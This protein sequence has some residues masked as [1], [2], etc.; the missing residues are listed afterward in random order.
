MNEKRENLFIVYLISFIIFG[1]SCRS[2]NVETGLDRVEDYKD[3]FRNKRVGI[4]TNNTAYD[5][6]NRY[7]VDIFKEM[8]DVKITAIFTPEHG[9]EGKK[10]PGEKIDYRSG[11][12]GLVPV[13]SLYGKTLKPTKEMV[14]NID[15]FVFD[16]QDIGA[17]F[18]TYI[19]TMALAMESAAEHGK[20][21]IVLDRPNPISGLYVEGNI[22]EEEFSSFVG[23]YPIPVRHGMTVGELAEMFNQQGWLKNGL[24]ADLFVVKL[25]GW[26]RFYFYDQ[27]GLRFIK[28]SPNIP[29]LESAI[30]YPG[31]CLL[32]GTNVSEGRGTDSPFLLFGA[33]WMDGKKVSARLN[34]LRLPGLKFV[35]EKFR[36]VSILGVVKS[37]KYL[38]TICDGCRIIILDRTKIRPYWT[39]INIVNTIYRLYPEK[40]KW[41]N[42]HFDNLCGSAKIRNAIINRTDLEKL[43]DQWYHDLNKFI[44]I[45]NKY[46]FYQ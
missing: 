13:Y 21:F 24:K 43:H 3:L 30:I 4:I 42:H 7:I 45:R 5:R 8:K 44:E 1:V 6:N 2:G 46:L 20:R 15:L 34:A 27:T 25:R 26:R 37:P 29:T 11:V 33:P 40:F 31:T 39:G 41:Y 36:P 38:N 35:N 16:I 12:W 17:R 14:E 23:L 28:P 10:E 18:Y 32:E 19:W 9:L 22:L